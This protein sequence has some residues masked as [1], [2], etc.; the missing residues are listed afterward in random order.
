MNDKIEELTKQ[1]EKLSIESNKNYLSHNYVN[2]EFLNV[3]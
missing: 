3:L 1:N 2:E